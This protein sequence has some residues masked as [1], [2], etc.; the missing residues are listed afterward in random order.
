MTFII[1]QFFFVQTFTIYDGFLLANIFLMETYL[2]WINDTIGNFYIQL[3]CLTKCEELIRVQP[4]E[5][6][7]QLVS[8]W[9]EKTAYEKATV[10]RTLSPFTRGEIEFKGVSVSYRPELGDVLRGVSFKVKAGE[11]VGVVGRTGSGKSTLFL[12]LLRIVSPRA[13]VVLVDGVDCS[14]VGLT[15][16][17]AS[18]NFILQ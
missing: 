7:K 3:K 13:G 15:S 8:E 2:G 1:I 11:K 12:A 17:R 14:L 9:N 16:L 6:Y 18:V 5:G 4:E 10:A